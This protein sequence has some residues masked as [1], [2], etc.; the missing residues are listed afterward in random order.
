MSWRWFR[1][2]SQDLQRW[3]GD[4]P[5][6]ILAAEHGGMI[7]CGASSEWESMMPAQGNLE[8]KPKVRDLFEHFVDRAPG[9]FIEE[10]E[11]SV[12]WHYR[13]ME[14]EFGE[15]L[16]GELTALLG[17]RSRTPMRIRREAEKSWKC[18]LAGRIKAR[19]LHR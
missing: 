9:S 7:R 10:K 5:K 11:F 4:V 19:S 2:A 17:G 12:V 13:R 3:L 15:W 14:P 16:A 6:L 1:G 18:G 8:W